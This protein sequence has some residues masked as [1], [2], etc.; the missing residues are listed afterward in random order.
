MKICIVGAGVSGLVAAYELQAAGHAVTVFES[1]DRVG[2]RM[3]SVRQNG[4]TLDI[5][6]NGLLGSYSAM[7]EYC[8]ALGVA[9]WRLAEDRPGGI[10]RAGKMAPLRG[11]GVLQLLK[12]GGLSW[13]SRILLGK[14]LTAGWRH[15]HL[16][17][18][19]LNLGEDSLDTEDLWTWASR[20]LNPEVARWFFDPLVRTFH[21]HS[22]RN[23]SMK[24]MYALM[25]MAAGGGDFT[26]Y[27]LQDYMISFPQAL[28]R[29]LEVRLGRPVRQIRGGPVV[30]D[31][32]VFDKVVVTA[33]APIALRILEN[34]TPEQ[35]GMLSSVRFASTMN[36]QLAI[37]EKDLGGGLVVW[38]PST[39]S[40]L[41]AAL[42]A[43]DHK[44]SVKNGDTVLQLVLHHEGAQALMEKSDEE[45]FDAVIQ[46]WTRLM[47]RFEGTLKPLFLK[48]WRYAIP[49]YEP[50]TITAVKKFWPHQGDGGIYFAGDWMNHPWS[51][52]AVRCGKR[53]AGMIG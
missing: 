11:A 43:E 36:V 16:D 25:A 28:A 45:V 24:F 14:L 30:V 18:H 19:D 32:E 50:G 29:D 6:V 31:G 38:M 1:E 27:F 26:T 46:E 39:E 35:R 23:L 4:F 13:W 40:S 48:R 51:E 21:F 3:S 17:L 42:T 41:I 37:S 9:P 34:P 22:P 12:F 7:R 49:I 53:V 44:G 47:P 52:G 15:R 33:P 10:Y 8:E 20:E 2:G 5:G